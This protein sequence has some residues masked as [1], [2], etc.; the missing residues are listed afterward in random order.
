MVP[1]LIR[2]FGGSFYNHVSISFDGSMRQMYSFARLHLRSPLVG[3]PVREYLCRY[4]LG[5]DKPVDAA[6]FALKISPDGY[7]RALER[8]RRIF[9]DEK[10][11]YN[12]FSVVSHPLTGG[13]PTYKAY[14]CSE[15]AAVILKLAGVG[16]D[17]APS[18]S[19]PDSLFELL[20]SEH[21]GSLIYLGDIRGCVKP[22]H[23][24]PCRRDGF[25]SRHEHTV[26]LATLSFFWELTKRQLGASVAH[27]K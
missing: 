18:K 5:T 25:F 8:T 9:G 21:G 3:G 10:Y 27:R 26:S 12:L 24:R 13:Y 17:I 23:G 1:A 4:T 6:V 15:F 7:A 19:T 16:A 11:V 22:P 2:T 20:R 14:S